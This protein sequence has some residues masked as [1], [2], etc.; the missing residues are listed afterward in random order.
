MK[1]SVLTIPLLCLFAI[2]NSAHAIDLQA[3]PKVEKIANELIAEDIYSANELS[4]IFSDVE[5]LDSVIKAMTS[6]AEFTLS[7]GRYRKI[8]LKDDRIESGVEFWRQH[9]SAFDRAE[10]EYGVPAE[11]IVAIIGVESKYGVFKGSHKVLDSLITLVSGYPRRSKFFASE[12]KHFLILCKENQI[13]VKATMGSYAGAMGFPQFISSSYRN[14]AIDFSGDGRI[15]LIDD[16]VDAIGSIANYFVENGWHA[17]EPVSSRAFKQLPKAVADLNNRKRKTQYS[18]ASLRGLG[19]V[20]P[21]SIDDA[22]LLNVLKL[23]AADAKRSKSQ[24]NTYMVRAGDTACAIAYAHSMSCREFMKLNNL[25]SKGRIYRGQLLKVKGDRKT[26][27][28]GSNWQI[29]KANKGE[30]EKPIYFYTHR[31]FYAITQYNHS[32]LYAMAVYDLSN[33]IR[34]AREG[35]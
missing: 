34:R 1:R 13:D 16:P 5:I 27:A 22:E 20:L 31:N 35:L 4:A 12:L 6:P 8:F 9:Q 25:D 32:V 7:W 30:P 28:D 24:P 26:K 14:Y 33:A 2:C 11:I 19:A 15:D 29:Q 3:H 17:G 23:D 18:A 21:A 10:A